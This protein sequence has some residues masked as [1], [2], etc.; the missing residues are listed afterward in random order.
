MHEAQTPS[1][2]DRLHIWC[3]MRGL[4][5]ALFIH[6]FIFVLVSRRVLFRKEGVGLLLGDFGLHLVRLHR[7]HGEFDV[8]AVNHAPQRRDLG[9]QVPDHLCVGMPHFRAIFVK[10]VI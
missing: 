6:S 9:P 3:S 4:I 1:Y 8:V 2:K 10:L 5:M 7:R